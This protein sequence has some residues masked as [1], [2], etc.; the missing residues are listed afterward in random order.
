MIVME[1]WVLQKGMTSVLGEMGIALHFKHSLGGVA[2][3]QDV[4]DVR[5]RDHIVWLT[6]KKIN[7]LERWSNQKAP[8]VQP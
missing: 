8:I 3:K 5:L 2:I 6:E 4:K 1:R 7:R